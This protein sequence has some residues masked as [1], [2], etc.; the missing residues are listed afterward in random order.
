[1]KRPASDGAS[2]PQMFFRITVPLLLPTIGFCVVTN[3]IG[4]MQMFDVAFVTTAGGPDA[5]HGDGRHV[6][7]QPR[8]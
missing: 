1:M 3:L 7:V 6:P 5:F 2:K 8:V 4:S